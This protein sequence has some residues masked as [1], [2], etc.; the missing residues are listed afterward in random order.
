MRRY[1]NLDLRFANDK[2]TVL[3][4]KTKLVKGSAAKDIQQ[5]QQYVTYE[6]QLTDNRIVAILAAT[7]T[8]EIRVWL[9]DSGIIDDEHENKSERVIRPLQIM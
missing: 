5:L 2:V 7:Q 8:D 4:N 6:R 3:G 1:K 9:D